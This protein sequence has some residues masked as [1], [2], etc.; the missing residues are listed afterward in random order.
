MTRLQF[1]AEKS[2]HKHPVFTIC[3]IK[4]KS[5]NAIHL[6]DIMTLFVYHRMKTD[7]RLCTALVA[8]IVILHNVH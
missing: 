3:T 5:K 1:F 7:F 4:Q 6:I 8:N 2:E